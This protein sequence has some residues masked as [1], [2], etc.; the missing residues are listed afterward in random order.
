MNED[1]WSEI[2]KTGYWDKCLATEIADQRI[3]NTIADWVWCSGQ[4]FPELDVQKLIN[5]IFNKHLA[6]DGIFGPSTIEALNSSDRDVVY[7]SLIER[8]KQYYRD[9]VAFANAKGDNSQDAFLA[10]W[11][12]RIDNLL[13]YNQ[14][15]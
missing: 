4:H 10:G 1:D 3:A 7:K 15:L 8:R 14:M 12:N 6:E 11:L 9:I 5:T 2:F 13:K